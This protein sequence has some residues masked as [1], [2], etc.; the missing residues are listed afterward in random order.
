MLR[1]FHGIRKIVFFPKSWANSVTS[2]IFNIG[3]NSGTITISN[4]TAEPSRGHGASFDVDTKRLA[5]AAAS[6]FARRFVSRFDNTGVDGQSVTLNGAGQLQV[7]AEWLDDF[8][9]Q[10]VKP[11]ALN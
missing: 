3:S 9:R 11:E 10:R 7:D 6:D 4:N 8:I 5:D 2:W 1:Y